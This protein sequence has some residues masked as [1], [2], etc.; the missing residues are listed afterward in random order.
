MFHFP[1]LY[2]QTSF[3]NTD[4]RMVSV[5]L[6]FFSCYTLEL[7]VL[8]LLIWILEFLLDF[9]Y[10]LRTSSPVSNHWQSLLCPQK[11]LLSLCVLYLLQLY[12]ITLFHHS[13]TLTV[14]CFYV[15]FPAPPWGA[16]ILLYTF[17]GSS[18]N[19]QLV[20]NQ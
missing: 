20:S 6:F 17:A 1:S 8:V 18:S 16:V 19:W 14:P 15:F 11:I 4:L 12:K 7:A 3:Y 9:K 2:C 10:P 13:Y 5:Q